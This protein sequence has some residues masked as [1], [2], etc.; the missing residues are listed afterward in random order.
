MAR[1]RGHHRQREPPKPSPSLAQAVQGEAPRTSPPVDVAPSEAGQRLACC[2]G[3]AP[4]V[5]TTGELPAHE[6]APHGLEVG[7][8]EG[9][10]RAPSAPPGAQRPRRAAERGA[11]RPR[12]WRPTEQAD[13]E[14]TQR[15]PRRRAGPRVRAP[16][17]T[18]KATAQRAA[19]RSGTDG[20]NRAAPS[21]SA[22]QKRERSEKWVP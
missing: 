22:K 1:Q 19:V 10:H 6:T 14:E 11:G 8:A 15:Q 3:T 17:A 20:S 13:E 16:P 9:D 7:A 18:E 21:P 2:D 12:R 4:E 5:T